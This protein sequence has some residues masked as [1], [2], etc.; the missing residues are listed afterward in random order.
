MLCRGR[1][2]TVVFIGRKLSIV[3]GG[4]TFVCSSKLAIRFYRA[5]RPEKIKNRASPKI[6][7]A[8]G[9]VYIYRLCYTETINYFF[10]FFFFFPF[11]DPLR[12]KRKYLR[13]CV[14]N[15]HE[16]RTRHNNVPALQR[17]R[18]TRDANTFLGMN[19]RK[20]R[21]RSC[22]RLIFGAIHAAAKP[23]KASGFRG[24]K[25]LIKNNNIFQ[26]NG[27]PSQFLFFYYHYYQEDASR[28]EVFISRAKHETL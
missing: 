26:K 19:S 17:L 7:G 14:Y 6:S 10:S 24:K 16:F 22:S 3:K 18:L 4:R 20:N 2:P 23:R 11:H 5:A 27:F 9:R 21:R 15:R 25:K 12:R 28:F 1:T 8:G 13:W